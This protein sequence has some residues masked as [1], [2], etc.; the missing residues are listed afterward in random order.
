MRKKV[1]LKKSKDD[2]SREVKQ[3]LE[4][5]S[6]G[7]RLGWERVDGSGVNVAQV[8]DVVLGKWECDPS[9]LGQW[10]RQVFCVESTNKGQD[11]KWVPERRCGSTRAKGT[12]TGEKIGLGQADW[13]A[14][15]QRACERE[16]GEGR[17][18]SR[19][20]LDV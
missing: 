15:R 8:N 5:R 6:K 11:K 20:R 16:E 7:V 1:L 4:G 17:G 18:K 10:R 9:V 2:T 14:D 3:V 13:Q 19:H 12:Q